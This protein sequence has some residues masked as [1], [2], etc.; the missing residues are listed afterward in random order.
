MDSVRSLRSFG[1]N[2]SIPGM[3]SFGIS[4]LGF[5]EIE[6]LD[7]KKFANERI[8]F[9]ASDSN[10]AMCMINMAL[11]L[12]GQGSHHVLSPWAWVWVLGLD[13]PHWLAPFDKP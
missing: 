9:T 4:F 7:Q 3:G 11:L 5:F 8:T 13:Y 12:H 6:G 10:S 1:N 2:H